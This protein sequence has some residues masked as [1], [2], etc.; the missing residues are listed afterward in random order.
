MPLRHVHKAFSKARA[1]RSLPVVVQRMKLGL[2]SNEFFG[3][4]LDRV[5]IRKVQLERENSFPPCAALKLI[6]RC[7]GLIRTP[8]GN[9]H[10]S[11]LR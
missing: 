9:I 11:P 1:Q 7:L 3:S 10:F 5:E 8:S 6:D 2:L 4:G